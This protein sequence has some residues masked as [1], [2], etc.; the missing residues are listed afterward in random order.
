LFED[1][2]FK[3]VGPVDGHNLKHMV[4]TLSNV[5][6]FKEPV[7]VHAVTCK[8]K[9]Y[10]EAEENPSKYHGI[11]PFD[12]DTGMVE[13]T[14]GRPT[15]TEV[16]GKTL[17]E[18]A[19]KDERIMAVTA[20]MEHGTGLAD[21]AAMFPERFVDV[22]IAEQH[23]VVFASGL[24]AEGLKPVVAIYSTFL[25]RSYDHII[26]DVCMQGAGV[27]LAADRAGIVG[28][29]GPTHHGVFDIAYLRTAPGIVFMAPSNADELR[30][31]LATAIDIDGPTAIR[32]PRSKASGYNPQRPPKPLPIGKGKLVRPGSDLCLIGLGSMLEPAMEAADILEKEGFSIAVINPRFI[33]PIDSELIIEQVRKCGRCLIVEEGVLKGGFGSAILELLSDSGNHDAQTYRMGAPDRFLEHG[34]RAELLDELDLNGEGIA[35][36]C[37][38]ILESP[39]KELGSPIPLPT[40]DRLARAR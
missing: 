15:Y 4:E 24:T 3:Y 32:Y 37:R 22:G 25:Q 6:R 8:G 35:A 36:R 40:G 9:G 29:D 5:R 11:G 16:F 2:G 26:H 28:E 21:F 12:P 14:A 34:T 1:L 31:M 17:C 30:D 33:K 19:Q 39:G 38:S 13:K 23:A 27:I 20:A 7:L 10:C 18:L